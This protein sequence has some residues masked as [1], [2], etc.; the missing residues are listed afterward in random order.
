MR[1]LTTLSLSLLLACAA[2][3]QELSPIVLPKPQT[4]GGKP[5]MQA[6][7][8]RA[9]QREFAPDPLPPQVLSNLLWAA[10]GINRPESGK[11]TAP[12]AMNRQEMDVYVATADGLY[13]YEA[14]EQRLKPVTKEDLRALTGTQAYVGMAPLNLVYVSRA[15]GDDA[16]RRD[17]GRFDQR[18]CLSLLR[19]GGPGHGR[20]RLD[21][22]RAAGQGDAAR[23]RAKNRS[24]ADGRLSE[25]EVATGL[26][27]T[28]GLSRPPAAGRT[29]PLSPGRGRSGRGVPPR[30]RTSARAGE[31]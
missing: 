23:T 27:A 6:L 16:R 13:L 7:R 20:P 26:R 2:V 9:S 1:K 31:T 17:P 5:L 12:S 30:R 3:A 19:L 8:D 25:E 4:D 11:R 10:W 18:E 15:G 29:P 24:R 14:K 22:S 28:A 21:Q